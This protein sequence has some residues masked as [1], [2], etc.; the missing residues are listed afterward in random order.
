[1]LTRGFHRPGA[2]QSRGMSNQFS[3]LS[4]DTDSSDSESEGDVFRPFTAGTRGAD[5]SS[6][7]STSSTA[8]EQK[9]PHGTHP[10]RPL[11]RM[12][13]SAKTDFWSMLRKN[14]ESIVDIPMATDTNQ[15]ASLRRTTQD[16]ITEQRV[17]KLFMRVEE[18]KNKTEPPASGL[19]ALLETGSIIAALEKSSNKTWAIWG[20]DQLT[21]FIWFLYSIAMYMCQC[22]W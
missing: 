13:T 2:T 1:M 3:K 18:L 22:G 16:L 6:S 17:V 20:T 4:L 7:S 8:G 21:W 14:R 12:N 11:H 9:R 5:H 10:T 15:S 19:P